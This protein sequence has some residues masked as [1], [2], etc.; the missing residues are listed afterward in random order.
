MHFDFSAGLT[1]ATLLTGLISGVYLFIMRGKDKADKE[2]VIVEYSKSFFPV[3][4]FVLVLR[5]FLF[6]PF[7]IPS[8]SMMPTLL[9]GDFIL[10]NKFSYGVRLP[11]IN[12]KIIDVDLPKRGDVMVFRYPKNPSYDY[13]K[14]VVGLPGDKVGYFDKHVYIN[15]VK[16]KQEDLGAYVGVGQG[17]NMTGASLKNEKSDALEHQILVM[18]DRPSLEGEIVVPEGHYFMMGDNR[19]NSNDS[20]YWGTVPEQNIVGKAVMIWMNWDSSNNGV[21]LGR[22]GGSIR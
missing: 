21:D 10:V 7:R 14:R 11:V 4:L 19:D 13:I 6:E 22:L 18:Q 3:L 12:M 5:S 15:N 20:R 1:L 8:S 2:P 16:Y 9:I 17:D